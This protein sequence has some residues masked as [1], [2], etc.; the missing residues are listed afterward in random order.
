MSGTEANMTEEMK[1]MTLIESEDPAPLNTDG[2]KRS[3]RR[4]F[5]RCG[6]SSVVFCIGTILASLILSVIFGVLRASGV[7]V[8]SFYE[9]NLLYFNEA[10]I[11]ISALLAA[12]VLIGTPKAAPEKK[13]MPAKEFMAIVCICF[14]VGMAGSLIGNIW[15]GFWNGITGNEV[16]N[17]VQELLEGIGPFQMIL[18]TAVLAPVLEELVFRKLFIDRMAK[19]GELMAIFVSALLFGLFHQNF[20]QF[21]YAFGLGLVFGYVYCRTSSYF[22][23]TL[24]HAIFNFVSGVLPMLLTDKVLVFLEKM[25]TLTEAEFVEVL[26]ALLGDHGVWIL[27][28]FIYLMIRGALNITG[29]VLF[30]L[31]FKKINI[32]RADST[33]PLAERARASIVNVGMIVAIAVFVI[34]MI[35]SLFQ[36]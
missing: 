24:L 18:C 27:I 20:S 33:L 36:G 9:K 22:L 19:H 30:I 12:L 10:I 23:V 34:M 13:K 5:S 25:E 35:I 2:E 31:N 21:F 3:I 26:P 16:T 1:D 28:Y 17:P 7:D 29:L 15:L 32:K 14:A 6:W 8:M 11:A 4:I